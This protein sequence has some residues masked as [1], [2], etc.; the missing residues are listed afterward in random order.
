MKLTEKQKVT[1][2]L[3]K[4]GHNEEDSTKWVNEH[5]EYVSKYYSGISKMAEVIASL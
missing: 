3:V 4:W 5:Y 2:R 1:A